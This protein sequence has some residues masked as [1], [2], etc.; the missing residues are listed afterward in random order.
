[1][2]IPPA[3]PTALPAFAVRALP[4]P[5]AV[6]TTIGWVTVM[7]LVATS[8]AT[9][10][11]LA[12][13]VERVK[14]S[15]DFAFTVYFVHAAVTCVHGGG[16]GAGWGVP[17]S[18]TWWLLLVLCFIITAALG[19][20]LCL[21]REMQ[22]ISVDEIV[23]NN[24]KRMAAANAGGAGAAG[25][26]AAGALGGAGAPGGAASSIGGSGSS[27]GAA[28]G[29]HH[30]G[31][32]RSRVQPRGEALPAPANEKTAVGSSSRSLAPQVPT[33][34]VGAGGISIHGPGGVALGSGSERSLVRGGG[35][36]APT[37]PVAA[38][39]SGRALAGAPAASSAAAV[40]VG[41]GGLGDSLLMR[42]LR[43]IF[44]AASSAG[45]GSY[46]SSGGG[47]G[48][49]RVPDSDAEVHADGSPATPRVFVEEA[50]SSAVNGGGASGAG[51]SRRG[52]VSGASA[53]MT[54]AAAAA[55]AS[56]GD[57][58]RFTTPL[59]SRQQRSSSSG[60]G[61]VGGNGMVALEMAP[62]HGTTDA[63]DGGAAPMTARDHEDGEPMP[64]SSRLSYFEGV[65][66]SILPG[67]ARG[68]F[69]RQSSA[70][71]TTSSTAGGP[72]PGRDQA[73]GRAPPGG[74]RGALGG[75]R[76]SDSSVSTALP[77]NRASSSSS[78]SS[79]GGAS[80]LALGSRPSGGG[81]AEGSADSTASSASA[82]LH[83][84]GSAVSVGSQPGAY[85]DL[86]TPLRRS[87]VTGGGHI[88]RRAAAH[89][90]RGAATGASA[91]GTNNAL[92]NAASEGGNAA[93][94]GVGGAA[95]TGVQSSSAHGTG[96]STAA[97]QLQ[98]VGGVGGGA[99][100]TT[101]EATPTGKTSKPGPA[102]FSSMWRRALGM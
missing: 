20:Y 61:G 39:S 1:M 29:V 79:M 69:S 24:R 81:S 86:T 59:K 12:L 4:Y 83:R 41:V 19:E 46:S 36:T 56:G 70:D 89:T 37:L 54:A 51:L 3:A 74:G 26:G 28:G 57:G 10:A 85:P 100:G 90:N 91:S 60:F 73:D 71:S 32:R 82:P 23:S 25:G 38:S 68:F 40:A 35:A 80:G 66:G 53:A 88:T 72:G 8:L 42:P 76:D 7:S 75:D 2:R 78:S 63:A 33:Q 17:R 97:P 13:V 98:G 43:G 22:D 5:P 95:A 101:P 21:R 102:D 30:A 77:A 84:V 93:S 27:G 92:G 15:L 11:W 55:A 18:G 47:G 87:A 67:I 44:R 52:S 58:Q 6:F 64:T 14:K 49:A 16:E 31:S 96:D 99:E 45:G 65:T 9:A 94:N 50:T 48:Y 34:T 62:Q